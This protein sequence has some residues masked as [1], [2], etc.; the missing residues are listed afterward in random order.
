MPGDK[1]TLDGNVHNPKVARAIVEELVDLQQNNKLHEKQF[2]HQIILSC[3]DQLTYFFLKGEEY[4]VGSLQ[5]KKLVTHPGT[6][7]LKAVLK[8]IDTMCFGDKNSPG[9]T[10]EEDEEYSQNFNSLTAS[11]QVASL[12]YKA[13][14]I[15]RLVRRRGV[16]SNPTPKKPQKTLKRTKKMKKQGHSRRKT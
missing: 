9:F 1:V 8:R 6:I 16:R 7:Q 2:P 11:P 10:V 12:K 3:N 4:K 5:D 15:Q 14:Q 13:E